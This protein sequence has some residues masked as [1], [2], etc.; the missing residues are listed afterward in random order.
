MSRSSRRGHR[1]LAAVTLAITASM[2]LASCADNGSSGGGE[3][4]ES[5]SALKIGLVNEQ[6]DPGTPTTGGTLTFSG[7]SAVTS[8]D[9]AKIQVAG[10]TGG[11]ELSAIYDVLMRYDPIE[12]TFVPQLAQ[13]L[14]PSSDS[15]TW[16]L[17]LRD[18]VKFSDGTSLDSKAVVD[19]INRYVNN[20]AAQSSL[21]A[22]KVASMD[23]PD[24][25]TVV[26]NLVDPW[27]G[28]ESMLSTGPGMIVAPAAQQ[29]DQFT[30]IGAGAFTLERFAPNE[31]LLLAARPDYFGGAPKV[32]KLKLISIVGAQPTAE[33]LKTGGIDAAY[34]RTLTPILD[35][36]ENGNPGFIDIPSLGYIANV[37]MA[38]GRPGSD[39]RVR[40]AM[41]MAID[42]ETL[43]TR[44]N[45]GKG[46]P[47][48]VIFQDTSRWHNDVAP[49]G[50]D[51][52]KAKELLD[53]AKADGYDGKV[54]FLS[55]QEPSAQSTALGVQAMLNAVG[56]DTQIEYVTGAG[57]LVK[58]MYVDRDYDMSTAAGSLSE[59]DP[60]ERLYTGIKSGG[61]NNVTNYADAEMDVLLDQ[62]GVATNDE[63]KKAVLA[64]IQERATETVP[65]IVWGN[66]PTLDV[67]N[68]NV[69][70]LKQSIDG[71]MLFDSVWKS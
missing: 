59:A 43:N 34:M 63:D 56:F 40:Q 47:G 29:G 68:T 36:I 39:L 20:K 45:N 35:L 1:R 46:L 2:F 60:F 25:S 5:G 6:A 28:I 11:S 26:F 42:P 7:Y 23:T 41:A 64:K 44:V 3:S 69:H 62:L 24:A 12:K 16:T 52:A 67:W 37:N 4:V 18:G 31:E 70:G 13:S 49:T 21:W 10:A 38:E 9:P 30:P 51:A 58:R 27:T 33:A 57:D 32:D 50:V 22:A 61:R 17:K 15:K 66:V 65:W 8:L 54:T 48:Q 55:I 19:S 53:Q 14:E 71:I